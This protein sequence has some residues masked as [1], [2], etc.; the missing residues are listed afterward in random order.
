M[1]CRS[2]QMHQK[3]GGVLKRSYCKGN[4]VPS[5]KQTTHKLP[6]TKGGLFAPKNLVYQQAGHSQSLT[7]SR[8]AECGSRQT[9]Q[10]RLGQFKQSGLSFQRSSRQ[11]VTGGTNLKKVQNKLHQFVSPV[12]DSLAWA[13]DALSLP[14]ADLDPYAFQPAA[15]LGKVVEKLKDYP[16]RR[17]ILIAPGWPNMPWFWDLVALFSQIPLSNKT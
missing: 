7:H 13:V 17:I 4:L 9:I 2:L 15:I 8:P 1:L 3:K 5:R 6:G 10:A 12:P 16:C 14:W 11:Y